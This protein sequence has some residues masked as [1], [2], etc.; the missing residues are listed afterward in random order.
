MICI[1][2]FLGQMHQFKFLVDL[3][4]A[5]VIKIPSITR[6][7]SAFFVYICLL[8]DEVFLPL[9]IGISVPPNLFHI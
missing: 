5:Y 7:L 1:F 3:Q 9:N 4:H 8:S 2:T 6:E